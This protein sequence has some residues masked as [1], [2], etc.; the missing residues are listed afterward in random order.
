[1]VRIYFVNCINDNNITFYFCFPAAS[2]RR[3]QHPACAIRLLLLVVRCVTQVHNESLESIFLQR[4]H[5]LVFVMQLRTF[6]GKSFAVNLCRNKL[7]TF[8]ISIHLPR[9][10][11]VTHCATIDSKANQ[12][13]ISSRPSATVRDTLGEAGEQLCIRLERDR[14][15]ED[16]PWTLSVAL[17]HARVL[18]SI[19]L[20]A[21]SIL[22]AN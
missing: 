20:S 16:Q 1:M 3:Y 10:R 22:N 5:V 12:K 9:R 17:L 4:A 8:Q 18:R 13:H 11:I 7:K 21:S 19:Y 2:G 14:D 15:F 6:Y